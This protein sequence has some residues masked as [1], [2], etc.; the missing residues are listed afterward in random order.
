MVPVPGVP[1]SLALSGARF[2]RGRLVK[3]GCAV[4]LLRLSPAPPHC[5]LTPH[6]QSTSQGRRQGPC[7]SQIG[8]SEARSQ[9]GYPG[10]RGSAP[11]ATWGAQVW[12]DRPAIRGMDA[13]RNGARGSMESPPDRCAPPGEPAGPGDTWGTSVRRG[14]RSPRDTQK[15]MATQPRREQVTAKTGAEGGPRVTTVPRVAA[16]LTRVSGSFSGNRVLEVGAGSRVAIIR[17]LQE[18]LLLRD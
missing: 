16:L 5:H 4:A 12:G 15:R 3:T 6:D 1:R 7:G 17:I 2:A 13:A 11:L 8:R 18:S 9:C 14:G 10:S